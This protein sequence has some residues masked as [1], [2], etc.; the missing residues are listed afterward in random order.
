MRTN[1]RT[2][3]RTNITSSSSDC[4][5]TMDDSPWKYIRRYTT[6]PWYESI[7]PTFSAQHL[8]NIQTVYCVAVRSLFTLV[9]Y[10]RPNNFRYFCVAV[11]GWKRPRER[12]SEIIVESWK[13]WRTRSTRFL[14]IHWKKP[15]PQDSTKSL[16]RTTSRRQTSYHFFRWKKK[17]IYIISIKK[18]KKEKCR[19]KIEPSRL[20]RRCRSAEVRWL[21]SL[22]LIINLGNDRSFRYLDRQFSAYKK[23]W[24]NSQPFTSFLTKSRNC[25][26]L[27]AQ[28]TFW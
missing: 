26:H 20:R 14:I 27:G 24:Q 12:T 11:V 17:C 2:K 6:P 19:L 18:K 21:I 10:T 4:M 9:F 13:M 23:T 15:D 22:W 25:I 3:V 1:A 16:T 8:S 7:C 28:L 5:T